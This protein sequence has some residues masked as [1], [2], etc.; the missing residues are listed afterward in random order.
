MPWLVQKHPGGGFVVPFAV[1]GF[2]EYDHFKQNEQVWQTCG[3]LQQRWRM[4]QDEA[5]L[6]R[7]PGQRG[8]ASAPRLRS[9]PLWV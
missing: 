9:A 6:R 2:S 1:A 3:V 5:L 7:N 4:K 8:R